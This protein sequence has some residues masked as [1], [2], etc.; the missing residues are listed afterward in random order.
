MSEKPSTV[1][2]GALLALGLSAG[3][4]LSEAACYDLTQNF[5]LCPANT[6]WAM[7]QWV[8][9]GDGA[10]LEG[11]DLWLEFSEHWITRQDGDTLDQALDGLLAEISDHAEDEG[12]DDFSLLIRDRFD[13][14][15][16]QVVRAV[17]LLEL[18]PEPPLQI[19]TMIAEAGGQRIMLMVGHV[20]VVET[21]QIDQTA[22]DLA[23]LVHPISEK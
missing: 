9:F 19:A 5:R 8:Q 16:L 17:Y 12:F 1:L 23:A 18:T 13:S 22:R 10:A 6:P 11:E 7:A 4:V 21:A 20:E 3:P 14:G 15:S 2:A